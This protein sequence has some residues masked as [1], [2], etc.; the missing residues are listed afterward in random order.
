MDF[1]AMGF[2]SYGP[3]GDYVLF[4][5]I[6][7]FVFMNQYDGT[8]EVK[9]MFAKNLTPEILADALV[10]RLKDWNGYDRRDIIV[11]LIERLL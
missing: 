1:E 8:Y 3:A 6:Y 2:K 4:D 9:G 5:D 7:Q 11:N 10:E